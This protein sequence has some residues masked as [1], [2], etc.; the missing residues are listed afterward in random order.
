[1]NLLD[2]SVGKIAFVDEVLM[3]SHGHGLM[4]RLEAMGI[5][6]NKPI[7]ILRKAHL[8]GPLH[9]RVGSTT[10]VAMRRSEAA[11]VKVSLDPSLLNLLSSS[12]G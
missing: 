1:M 5:I 7:Q 8:G 2:L 3:G 10:E 9:I 12:E 4:S 11:L 6:P